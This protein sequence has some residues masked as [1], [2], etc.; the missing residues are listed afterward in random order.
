MHEEIFEVSGPDS[1]VRRGIVTP[2]PAGTNAT[3]GILLLPAGLKYHIGPHRMYVLMARALARQGYWVLRFDPLGL[4]ESDGA[5]PP[6]PLRDIWCT[7]ERGR[8]VADS[9]LACD[10][11]RQRYA[12]TSVIVGGLCGGAITAQSAAAS[13][14]D[15][16]QG[17]I[18]LNTAVTLSLPRAQSGQNLSVFQAR[19]HFRDYFRKFL[20]WD[21]WRR[22]WRGESDYF[23]IKGTVLTAMRS[24]L[25]FA[26]VRQGKPLPNENP[27][28][29][30]TFLQLEK[31][32]TRHLL[33]FGENDNRWLE[34]SEAIL[35][36][37]LHGAR[38]GSGYEVHTIGQ[39]N[40]EFHLKPWQTEACRLILDWLAREFPVPMTRPLS[41]GVA[42]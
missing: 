38:R 13:R 40:H 30:R 4:G 35:Q 8:F 28:F 42:C 36:G 26:P 19:H 33:L 23:A 22:V 21:A 39:A 11:W 1:L 16:F 12:L 7:V 34:F 20:S 29:I 25:P 10:A 5:I 24:W 9:V 32:A 18:S 31:K 27:Q 17:V 2:P 41:E 14:P 37:Y 15:L 3:T 6:A